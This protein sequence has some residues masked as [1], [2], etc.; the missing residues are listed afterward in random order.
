MSDTENKL[1]FQIVERAHQELDAEIPH[2]MDGCGGCSLSCG[3]NCPKSCGSGCSNCSNP[4]GS[5]AKKNTMAKE[6]KNSI[7]SWG[8]APEKSTEGRE[9]TKVLEVEVGG[10]NLSSGS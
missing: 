8:T 2:P 4:C 3:C 7:F 9:D 6:L 10:K 5:W 1:N